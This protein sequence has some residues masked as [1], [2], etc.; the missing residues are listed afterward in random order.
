MDA[1]SWVVLFI[2]SSRLLLDPTGSEVNTVQVVLSR[3]SVRL[4]CFVQ[5]KTLCR[6]FLAAPVCVCVCRCNG[7]VICVRHDLNLCSGW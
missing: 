7:D 2:L 6:Y 5:A 1:L 4:L 3:F